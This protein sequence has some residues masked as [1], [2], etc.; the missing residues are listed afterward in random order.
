VHDVE[1]SPR[2]GEREAGSDSDRHAHP[3]AARDRHRRAEGNQ[4]GL[5]EVAE[6]RAP[7]GGQIAGAVRRSENGDR[8]AAAP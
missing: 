3:A 2:E 1:A 4:L 8:V 5:A 6:Q 7:S